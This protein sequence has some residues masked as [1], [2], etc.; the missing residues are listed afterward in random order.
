MCMLPTKPKNHKVM[1]LTI[2]HDK[3]KYNLSNYI[4]LKTI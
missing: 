1:L 4:Y 2:Q 3:L